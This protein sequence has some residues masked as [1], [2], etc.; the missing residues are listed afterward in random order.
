MESRICFFAWLKRF[1]W[2]VLIMRILHEIHGCIFFVT[3]LE[4][5]DYQQIHLRTQ[6]VMLATCKAARPCKALWPCSVT[7]LA[8]KW[9]LW[10]IEDVGI[11]LEKGWF[12]ASYVS[13]KGLFFWTELAHHVFFVE[14]TDRAIR[15]CS[16]GTCILV[17]HQNGIPLAIWLPITSMWSWSEM[18]FS[19]FLSTRQGF[20]VAPLGFF[21]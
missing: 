6:V 21:V 8:G 15:S 7:W 19:I 20:W 14:S 11:L 9:T 16:T 18:L 4:Q 13:L 10:L 2:V 17:V 5:T 3:L 12:P 1:F